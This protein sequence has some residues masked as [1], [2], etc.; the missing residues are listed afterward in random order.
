V[1]D[2]SA[3]IALFATA[4]GH[5]GIGWTARGLA[6][7]Q[8]PEADEVRTRARLQRRL[9]GR[10]PDGVGS[11]AGSHAGSHAG[12][13]VVRV[14][15]ADV[16]PNATPTPG[17][18]PDAVRQAIAAIVQLLAGERLAEAHA[19]LAALVLDDADQP[20]L[21]RRVHAAA[22]AIPPGSTCTYGDLARALGDGALARAVGQAMGRNPWPIVVPCHRVLGSDGALTGFSA[23]GGIATK[24]RMLAIEGVRLPHTPSLFGDDA[25]SS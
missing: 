19:T 15:A 12:A 2:A 1:T 5:C 9:A 22:R 14:A 20:A 10:V 11:R 16:A 4:I 3:G 21:Y 18:M 13:Q 25:A 7:V 17:A 6:G 23:H 24:R 8:L